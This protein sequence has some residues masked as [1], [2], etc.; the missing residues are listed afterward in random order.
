M[1]QEKK[2]FCLFVFCT[3]LDTLKDPP[4]SVGLDANRL[5]YSFTGDSVV[6][7]VVNVIVVGTVIVDVV[8]GVDVDVVEVGVDVDVLF[9]ELKLAQNGYSYFR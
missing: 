6:V 7:V 2:T 4:L 8:V 1:D 3:L 9:D 5:F